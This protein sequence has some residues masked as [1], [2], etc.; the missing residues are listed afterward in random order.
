MFLFINDLC[1]IDQI[2]SEHF[3]FL[4]YFNWRIIAS[5]CCVG[6]CHTSIWMSHRYT[7][8]PS[9]LN[10]LLTF[11]STPPRQ[12]ITGHQAEV[13]AL[14]GNFTL[15]ICFTH[16]NRHISMLLSQFVS[17]SPSLAMSISLFSESLA[18]LQTSS[19]I[20]FFQI[21]YT[22]INIWCFSLSDFLHSR[23]IHLTAT[24]LNSF[25]FMAE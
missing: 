12:V 20:P 17:S 18:A 6:F 3:I 7:Y 10:L 25:I 4:I 21:P 14:Y 13:P 1:K 19:S 11:L 22:C 9:L 2:F 5:Q 8:I 16:C 24:D 15:A 23:L